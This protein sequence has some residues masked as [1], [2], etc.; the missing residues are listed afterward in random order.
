MTIKSILVPV[1]EPRLIASSLKAAI[2]VATPF[3]AHVEVLHAKAD[4]RL[5]ATA[6]MSDTISGPMVEQVMTDT[7]NRA[8]QNARKTRDAFDKAIAAAKVR[9]AEKPIRGANGVTVAW[10]ED[11]G[12]EDQLLRKYGRV[13]DL[14]VLPRPTAEVD[15]GVR[16]S[17][18]ASLMETGRPLLLVPP[19]VPAKIG[20]NIAIA[21]NGS[22]EAARAV[23]EAKA[24]FEKARKVTILTASEKGEDFD[25]EGVQRLLGWHGL[26]ATIERVRTRGDIGKGLLNAAT[27]AGADLL[28][29]G[30]YSHSRVR[31][32]IL[33]GVTRHVLS[34]ATMPAL[35]AH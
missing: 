19:K 4:A 2:T 6:Y 17:L 21:W 25:P 8:T 9:Y 27:R 24:F 15:V 32:M 16:L 11:T 5:V 30:A 23:D 18:E 13:S 22:T 10:R 29:M 20:S 3:A 31:E 12:E 14:V 35:M 1:S 28:V 34:N 33:G 26:K 7:E